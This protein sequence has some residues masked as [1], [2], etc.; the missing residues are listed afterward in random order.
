MEIFSKLILLQ[1]IMLGA[2]LITYFG[3][4]KIEGEAH[5]IEMHIDKK[6]AYIPQ[7][8]FVY[9][10]WFP[11]IAVFPIALYFWD[12]YQVSIYVSAIMLDIL[13]STVIYFAYPTSFT[14]P[15]PPA[16]GFTGWV[17]RTVYK[18]DYKGK[19][20]MPSMHCSFC[21]IIIMTVLTAVNVPWW[22]IIIVCVLALA[23][24]VSTVFTKQHVLI[25]MITALPLAIVCFIIANV[26]DYNFLCILLGL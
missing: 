24:V 14:R 21:F 23:I 4:Q 1:V 19:N 16:K 25:D 11:L 6:I 15:S 22:F 9:I 3:V 20:C 10:T 17:M 5:N 8:V 18:C 2:Q 26:F 13:I 12:S 7:F